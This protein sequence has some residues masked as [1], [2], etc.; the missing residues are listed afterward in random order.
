MKRHN[1]RIGLISLIVIALVVGIALILWF[2]SGNQHR[3]TKLDH[4]SSNERSFLVVTQHPPEIKIG[5]VTKEQSASSGPTATPK[6]TKDEQKQSDLFESWEIFLQDKPDRAAIH[7]FMDSLSIKELMDLMEYLCINDE[8]GFVEG[9]LLGHLKSRWGKEIPF[10]LLLELATDKKR[11]TVFRTVLTDIICSSRDITTLT[12]RDLISSHLIPIA[13]DKTEDKEL[14]RI[15]IM[16]LSSMLRAGVSE[17]NRYSDIFM[18][19]LLET[20][21]SSR[22]RGASVTALRR[23]EDN[24]AIP[25]LMD[26]SMNY[27]DEEDPSFARHAVVA[28]AKYAKKDAIESP[29]DAIGTVIRTTQN[30]R[31]YGSAVYSL[32]LLDHT[33]FLRFLPDVLNSLQNHNSQAAQISVESALEK[34]KKAVLE[35]LNH[36]AT[37]YVI[38]GI[39]ASTMVP[40]PHAKEKLREL[41]D[42]FPELQTSISQALVKADL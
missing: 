9:F 13:V 3:H 6:V 27:A 30:D 4:T 20:T 25:I 32:S 33:D 23:M 36:E 41:S 39:T 1:K 18:G 24:R 37:T 14:R 16:K 26:K 15:V 8:L 2:R 5:A 29:A 19:L 22:V 12:E 21:E 38:A 34:H 17:P 42:K 31:V 35:A 7:S 11:E 10:A 28:L 40:M